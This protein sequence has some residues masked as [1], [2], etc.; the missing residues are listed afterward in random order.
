MKTY[1][2][3]FPKKHYESKSNEK[4]PYDFQDRLPCR[5]DVKN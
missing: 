2:T 5:Y 4:T 3:C 1:Q